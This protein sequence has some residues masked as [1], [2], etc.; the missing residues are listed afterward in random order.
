VEFLTQLIS[1]EEI[2]N[3]PI[4]LEI[5]LRDSYD[6]LHSLQ[7]HSQYHLGQ[8]PQTHQYQSIVELLRQDTAA[9]SILH[10]RVCRS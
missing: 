4:L 8:H 5:F 2:S 7:A 10:Y 1:M 6:T 9:D 3:H